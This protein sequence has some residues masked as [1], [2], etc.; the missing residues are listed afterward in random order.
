M[1]LFLRFH[2]TEANV[3]RSDSEV[4]QQMPSVRLGIIGTSLANQNCRLE[5]YR[6]AGGSTHLAFA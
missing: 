1:K 4:I 3:T 2:G 5:D 6:L